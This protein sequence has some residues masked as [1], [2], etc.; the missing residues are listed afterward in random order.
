MYAYV[1][2][3]GNTG[4]ALW[5]ADQPLYLTAAMMTKSN[6]DIVYAPQVA[7]IAASSDITA[8]HANEMGVARIEKIA[9][10]LCRLVWDADAHFFVARLEKRYLAATKVFDTLFD[11]FEN[12]A[13]PTHVYNFRHFKLLLLFK[14]AHYVLTDEICRMMWTCIT[15]KHETESRRLLIE[16]AKGI[17]ANVH[18]M[19]DER[20][21]KS[22]LTRWNGPAP[23]LRISISIQRTRSTGTRTRRTS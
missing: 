17:L 20:S 5:D 10:R 6:F 9:G 8:L 4:Y 15:T 7:R 21:R 14:L 23:T 18:A 16:C 2:E 12:L 19:P 13:V 3:S 1:D 11:S 22:S